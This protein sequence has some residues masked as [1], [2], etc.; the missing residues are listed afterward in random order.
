MLQRER[1]VQRLCV[2]V[3]ENGVCGASLVLTLTL[4]LQSPSKRE[5]V[6][7]KG[8]V[9]VCYCVSFET[10]TLQRVILWAVSVLRAEW[11]IAVR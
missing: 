10:Q 6:P 9:Y 8:C 7:V 5:C 1:E 2:R 4:F 11:R 3:V